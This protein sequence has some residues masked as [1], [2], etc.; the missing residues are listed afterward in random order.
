MRY[1]EFE[2][3]VAVGILPTGLG[4]VEVRIL[5][6]ETGALLGLSSNIANES[7]SM[8]GVWVFPLSAITD[9]IMGFTQVVVEF[10]LTGTGEK[11]YAKLILRGYVDE[12]RR[13]RVLVAATL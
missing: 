6:L 1:T 8:P 3:P 10:I 13:T 4:P 12:V 9:P 2:S 11:D 5:N 7:T